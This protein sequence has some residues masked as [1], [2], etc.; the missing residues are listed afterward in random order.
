[1]KSSSE[2]FPVTLLTAELKDDWNE[3]T[4]LLKPNN[5]GDTTVEFALT[6]FSAEHERLG[7]P[8][9]WLPPFL[10]GRTEWLLRS[11][12]RLKALLA[13]G[14][15]VWFLEWRGHGAS[16][17]NDN[18]AGNSLDVIACCDLPAA[19]DFVLEQA[20]QH[21]L[22]VVESSAAQV[23]VRA[24][25]MERSLPVAG[26]LLLW[27]A[28]GR[29]ACADYAAE[30]GW[31]RHELEMARSGVKRLDGHESINRP[32][33][34]ELLLGQRAL[35]GDW[36][37]ATQPS[38]FYLVDRAAAQ[39]ATVRWLSKVPGES[40]LSVIAEPDSVAPH[41]LLEWCQRL[42]LTEQ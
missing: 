34:D 17:V 24:H 16:V 22:L 15:D 36:H 19:L 21:A 9:L 33:F 1:M 3:D 18:W 13:Q 27:P 10:H 40:Y 8:I 28:L 11:E 39:K 4:Y 20:K 14:Y 32:L 42:L 37:Y 30:M 6:R 26:S 41:Q 25:G 29:K 7:Q 12:E 31:Q 2:L 23:W 35:L 5:S 38:P